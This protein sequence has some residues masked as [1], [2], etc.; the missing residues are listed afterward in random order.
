MRITV[1]KDSNLEISFPHDI[2]KNL[3][4]MQRPIIITDKI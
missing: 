3:P 1:Q 2:K 4:E